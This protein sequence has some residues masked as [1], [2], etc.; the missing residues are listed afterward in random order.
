M[1][2]L[3]KVAI[4]AQLLCLLL[5]PTLVGWA[6]YMT[7]EDQKAMSCTSAINRGPIVQN[8]K[9]IPECAYLINTGNH[10]D[11]AQ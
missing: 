9:N 8:I 11:N 6:C 3:E 7:M 5:T 1:N 10:H 4:A 2:K